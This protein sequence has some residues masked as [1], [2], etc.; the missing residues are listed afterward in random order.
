MLAPPWPIA[1]TR[2]LVVRQSIGKEG[3]ELKA[4]YKSLT[5]KRGERR[6][7]IA[8]ARKLISYPC[9]ILKRNEIRR[10]DLESRNMAFNQESLILT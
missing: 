1:D 6:T 7:L 5:R 3:G 2:N 4:F 9:W 10:I 8:V